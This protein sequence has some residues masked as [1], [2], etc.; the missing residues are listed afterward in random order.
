MI[1]KIVKVFAAVCFRV[2]NLDLFFRIS[3]RLS[4]GIA[5]LIFFKDWGLRINGLPAYYDH[6]LNLY[7]WI[8]NPEE[9]AFTARGVYARE[10]MFRGCKVLDLCCGDGS[11][12]YFYFSDIAGSIDAVDKDTAAIKHAAKHYCRSNI[13]YH[14]L[15]VTKDKLPSS[16]YDFIVWNAAICYFDIIDIQAVLKKI[17]YA[18]NP[19]M[20]FYGM[21]P[22]ATGYVDH[23]TEFKDISE[24]KGLLM[25]Y[26]TYVHIWSIDE[27]TVKNVYFYAS[28]PIKDSQ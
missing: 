21:T 15:D 20:S 17:A 3:Q 27:I 14:K 24:L 1:K 26:F 7:K 13:T 18:G 28:G 10:R 2:I 22:L 5:N 11:Y 4:A 9:W 23:R 6:R 12:S 16:D 19:V 25:Q 8:Y